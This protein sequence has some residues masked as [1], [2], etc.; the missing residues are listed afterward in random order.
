MA[1]VTFE[2]LPSTNT[3]INANNLNNNF[4]YLAPTGGIMEFAGSSA[5]SGWLICDGSAVSRT[6][7]ADL[8]AVIGTTYGNGNGSTTFNL[9]NLTGRIPIGKKSSD[10][11]FDTLGETGGSKTHTQTR[12]EV[13]NHTHQLWVTNDGGDKYGSIPSIAWSKSADSWTNTQFGVER[14]DT[15][16]ASPMN[17]MN[18]YIVLN[19][20]IKY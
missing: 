3:P 11:D 12:D 4:N 14:T 19:Y 13:A 17:I 6:T 8:Y 7:Y 10:T 15:Q 5:P 2:D 18:P 16:N 20:I 1:K 9:P